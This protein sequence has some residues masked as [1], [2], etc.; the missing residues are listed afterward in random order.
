MLDA[1]L[2]DGSRIQATL[3][4]E[5]TT[6]GSTFT[7]RKFRAIPYS[8]IELVK[9]NTLSPEMLVYLWM[10]VEHGASGIFA[11]GTASGKTTT[12]NAIALFI[13]REAKIVSIE[14]TRELNLP[15]PNW[16]PGVTR[17][18]FGEIVA[19]KVVGE[20]DMYDLLKAAL[21]QR[22]EYIIVGEIRGREAYVLFQA[23]ATGHT[24]YSTMHADSPQ[25]LIHRLEGKPINIPRV[26]LQ[27]L[28]VIAIQT[29]ARVKG[30]RVR[31][32]KQVVEIVDIDPKTKEILTNE[33]FRWDPVED[34]F[35]YSGRSYILEKI[36]ASTGM[37]K[38]EMVEEIKRRVKILEWMRKEGIRSYKE[39][40]KIVAEYAEK[41]EEVMK[42]VEE[43]LKK[44]ASK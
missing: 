10:A 34:T 26:M 24:T 38:E 5:V 8:P 7:I 21:R 41:P 4:T 33:V 9:M 3:G 14:E 16:I 22:P 29:I 39:V 17:S 43:G 44:H 13:P 27:A 20:I 6:R 15:H 37:S 18:G 42:R 25:S 23:M 40:A 31:R 30:K 28:E 32:C 11:G 2:P 19:D 36:R 12:L 1:T 35:I